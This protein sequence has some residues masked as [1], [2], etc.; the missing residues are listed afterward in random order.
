LLRRPWWYNGYM[1][2]KIGLFLFCLLFLLAGQTVQSSVT[3]LIPFGGYTT[4]VTE[5][6]CDSGLYLIN[7]ISAKPDL[8]NSLIFNDSTSH[9]Y[10]FYNAK[11]AGVHIL[12]KAEPKWVDCEVYIGWDCVTVGS[13]FLIDFVGSSQTIGSPASPNLPLNSPRQMG[14]SSTNK[15]NVNLSAF[16]AKPTAKNTTNQNL[17]SMFNLSYWT[18]LVSPKSR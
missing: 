6:T 16:I 14:L 17:L 5:C 2:I 3:S 7:L 18:N 10:A 8:P 9:Q 1:K 15:N 4:E 12:G 13:G 11:K